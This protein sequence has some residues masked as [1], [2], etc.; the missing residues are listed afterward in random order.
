MPLAGHQSL[1]NGRVGHTSHHRQVHTRVVE[2]RPYRLRIRLG[3]AIGCQI[4]R[5]AGCRDVAEALARRDALA[6]HW[7]D[8]GQVKWAEG[9]NLDVL[10]GHGRLAGERRVTVTADDGSVVTYE[11]SKA[12]IVATGTGAAHPPIAGLSAVGPWDNRDITTAKDIPRRLLILGGGVVG[13][14]MAQAFATL[15][16]EEVV[17]IEAIQCPVIGNT[18]DLRYI[19]DRVAL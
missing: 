6:S 18:A 3:A 17:I 14:E 5:I 16:S 10:R 8:A 15:G 9:A 13:V 4:Q 12:V 2:H 7:D 1:Q 11:V 19:G